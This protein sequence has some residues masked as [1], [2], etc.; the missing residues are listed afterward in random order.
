[1]SNNYAQLVA[2]IDRALPVG[3]SRIPARERNGF[4]VVAARMSQDFSAT[5]VTNISI[6]PEWLWSAYRGCRSARTA[7]PMSDKHSRKPRRH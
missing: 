1:M 5:V 7:S 4:S 6:Y 2:D 3:W